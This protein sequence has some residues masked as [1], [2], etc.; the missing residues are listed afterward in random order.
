[1]TETWSIHELIHKVG[2]GGRG[3]RDLTRDEARHMAER[4]YRR[5]L[6]DA[7]LGAFLLA[8]R[9]KGETAEEV[10]AFIETWRA[11]APSWP[12]HL[13]PEALDVAGGYDG[14]TKTFCA[15]VA[16]AVLAADLGV[17]QFLHGSLP[18]PPKYGLTVGEVLSALRVSAVRAESHADRHVRVGIVFLDTE[19]WLS[20]LAEL[21]S[22]REQLGLRTFIH[23]VEKLINPGRSEYRIVG[24]FHRPAFERY[25]AVCELDGVRRC[26]LIQGVEG[27]EDP[28]PNRATSVY[29][30]DGH[31]W[32]IEAFDPRPYGL[33]ADPTCPPDAD[34]QARYTESVLAGEKSSYARWAVWSAAVR[35]FARG[36]AVSLDEAVERVRDHWRTGRAEGRLKQWQHS[37][38]LA[39]HAG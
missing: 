20:P 31:R 17:K 39:P 12:A 24:A 32:N 5:D 26:V 30:F 7:Q 25:A 16:A 8:E 38:W 1:M 28:Y 34:L 33:E 4:M 9:M 21:R 18:L 6:T 29:V 22:V 3:A 2:R 35:L 36:A 27:S 14:R 37:E 13:L 15:S 11:H 19:S 10:H 23:S